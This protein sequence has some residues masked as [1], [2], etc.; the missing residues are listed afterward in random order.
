METVDKHGYI[1][2][3]SGEPIPKPYTTS[4]F[5]IAAE[6]NGNK[7]KRVCEG[8][9]NNTAGNLCAGAASALCFVSLAIGNKD[10]M[11]VT[12]TRSLLLM[13]VKYMHKKR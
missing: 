6:L 9:V 12:H 11:V 10:E 3:H 1:Y 8:L 7:C 4:T 13:S 5:V 2:A